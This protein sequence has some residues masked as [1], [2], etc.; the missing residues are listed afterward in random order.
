M[1]ILDRLI[2]RKARRDDPIWVRA[3]WLWLTAA[4]GVF[5]LIG[6]YTGHGFVRPRFTIVVAIILMMW[7]FAHARMW[8]VR[9]V[10][11]TWPGPTAVGVVLAG[12]A[13]AFDAVMIAQMMTARANYGLPLITGDVTSWIGPV[14]FSSHAMIFFVLGLGGPIKRLVRW[15]RGGRRRSAPESPE[16]REFL[17]GASQLGVGLPFAI[18]LSGVETSYDFQVEER[19]IVLANWPRSLDGMRIAH[20]SDIHVGGAM[21]R[22]KLT[23][24]AEL[25]NAAKVDLVLHTGDFLT[26]RM[27]GFDEPLYEALNRIRVEHG[28][29]ACLGNHDYDDPRRFVGRLE[30]CGVRVLRNRL[31]TL[32]VAGER[33]EIGGLDFA[34]YGRDRAGRYAAAIEAW[35][36]RSTAPRV[37]LCHDPS[38]FAT[39]PEGCA[40]LVLSGHTHGGH[41]GVQFGDGRAVTVVG[42]MGIPDQGVFE[43]GEMKLY[44]TRCVGFYGYPIR[45]G[46]PPE[47][48]I[49]NL[50]SKA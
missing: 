38:A 1:R 20:L 36:D 37:L 14:W 23:T 32:E 21:D 39:L 43:R 13:I 49:L 40:D 3:S 15:M 22:E 41:V 28:Q 10:S 30:G 8:L 11:R 33:V 4:T 44:V 6:F 9:H 16:R 25:T 19:E 12:I 2:R 35:G 7:P 48:A 18:S 24:V 45:L 31:A 17:R 29:W 26:H 27:P 42:L 47:I 50:R 5:A 46:V 34:F